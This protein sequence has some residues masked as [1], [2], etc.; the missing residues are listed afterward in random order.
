ML[1]E[2]PVIQ[3]VPDDWGCARISTT[4]HPSIR[5]VAEDLMEL[6]SKNS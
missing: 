4:K 1:A 3:A 2:V 6:K 5:C